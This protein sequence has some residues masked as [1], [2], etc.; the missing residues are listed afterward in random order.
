MWNENSHKTIQYR[1]HP[2]NNRDDRHNLVPKPLNPTCK[3]DL[4]DSQ[5]IPMMGF[6]DGDELSSSVVA[7]SYAKLTFY[8][9]S[10]K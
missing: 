6:C 3:L 10:Q 2:N 7:Q 1:N 8:K 9:I 5:L 4:I